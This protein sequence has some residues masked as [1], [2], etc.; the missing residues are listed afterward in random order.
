MSNQHTPDDSIRLSAVTLDC[1]D[2]GALAT[3][4]AEITGGTVTVQDEGWACV[5]TSGGRIY[6]Q[7][8]PGHTA[9]TWPTGPVPAQAHLDL[10]VADRDAADARVLAA[11]ATR[12]GSQPNAGQC[13]V[14]ADPAG[15]PFCLTTFE[16]PT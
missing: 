2:A 16:A 1:P 5:A 7:T 12:Y 10:V 15:H 11:G 4:Y 6:L 9:P 8:V 14:Y 13:T 3:F